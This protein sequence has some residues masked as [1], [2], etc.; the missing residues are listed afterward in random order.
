MT[1]AALSQPV[2]LNR[3]SG[4][5]LTFPRCSPADRIAFRAI[6][7]QY[8][9]VWLRESLQVLGITGAA[10]VDHFNAL[11]R[12]RLYESDVVRWLNEPEGQR[13]AVLLSL[14]KDKAAATMDD[15]D[16]FA[17]DDDELLTVA[18]GVF[19]IPLAAPKDDTR[20]PQGGTAVGDATATPSDASAAT[21]TP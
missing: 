16:A 6:F 5:T 15:V 10:A 18:A 8:R 2:T 21:P 12:A 3:A 4:E 1:D 20:P 9:K 14:R 11:D 7:R 13:E 19:N 17:L